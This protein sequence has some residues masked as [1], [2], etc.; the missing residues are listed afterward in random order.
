[1]KVRNALISAAPGLALLFSGPAFA[2]DQN[3]S[4]IETAEAGAIEATGP[5]L[6]KVADEDT[7]IWLFGTVHA[8]PEGLNWYTGPVEA[9]LTGSEELVTE[10][11]ADPNTATKM[12]Q[13][14]MEKGVLPEDQTLRGLLD[15]DQTARFEAA[16]TKLGVPVQAFDRYEPW[17]GAMVL[18]MLPLLQQGYSADTGVEFSLAKHA[19]EE[20]KRGELETIEM[21]LAMFDELPQ[22]KQ[23]EFMM[24]TVDMVDEIKPML[25][26]MVAE[27]IE[28]DADALAV[29]MNEN[30]DDPVLAETLLY[31]RN[32]AWAEWIDKRLDTPGTIF[33]AVGAGHLAGKQSVQDALTELGIATLRVQ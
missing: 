3:Q 11:I 9:A 12:Q 21:Q 18:S 13:L 7:T 10:I 8:L 25:D 28:G 15:E 17:Y 24:E 1:M 16:L 22:D 23:I 2:E 27:W 5:A 33:I 14:V 19:G 26:E 20:K 4:A 29:L 30:M 32:R 31:T 6:W